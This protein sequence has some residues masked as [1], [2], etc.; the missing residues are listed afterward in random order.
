[1]AF[2]VTPR[3]VLAQFGIPESALVDK[4]IS[5]SATAGMIIEIHGIPEFEFALERYQGDVYDILYRERGADS[6]WKRTDRLLRHR[7][8]QPNQL[9]AS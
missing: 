7:P 6:D 2:S 9:Y 3:L 5:V 8:N 4:T 1:M